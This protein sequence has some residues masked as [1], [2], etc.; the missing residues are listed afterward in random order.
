MENKD[1]ENKA[2][3]TKEDRENAIKWLNYLKD[4]IDTEYGSGK[5]IH[6]ALICAINTINDTLK[7]VEK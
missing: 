7:K 4:E 1:Y 6:D 3:I 2:Y 5:K